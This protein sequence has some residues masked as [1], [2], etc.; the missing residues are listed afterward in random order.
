MS[1][2]EAFVVANAGKLALA[3]GGLSAVSDYQSQR[4]AAAVARYNAEVAEQSAASQRQWG[5]AEAARAREASR[6]QMA[7]MRAAQGA[8]GVEVGSGSF[9]DVLADD[10]A[11]GELEALSLLFESEG[12]AR[13]FD[14]QAALARSQTGTSFGRSLLAGVS[15]GLSAYSGLGGSFGGAATAG[16]QLT[17]GIGYNPGIGGAY[18]RPNLM[19]GPVSGSYGR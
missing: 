10:A 4:Q 11:V 5:E 12:R 16:N 14:N 8:S 15:T 3:A 6:R 19:R 13:Q 1:G 2:I 17:A 9:G 7:R 18:A